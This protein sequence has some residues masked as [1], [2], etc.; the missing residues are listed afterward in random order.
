MERRRTFESIAE[1]S[2]RHKRIS[3]ARQ[4]R[5]TRFLNR[6]YTA[7]GVAL[8]DRSYSLRLVTGVAIRC[9]EEKRECSWPVS[10]KWG[11][12]DTAH[13]ERLHGAVMSTLL[14]LRSRGTV[15]TATLR[16][17]LRRGQGK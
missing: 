2:V 3:R 9:V 17:P 14:V 11:C 8:A 15:R 6:W 13:H 10:V 5:T 7:R 1:R 4:R 16:G 12:E